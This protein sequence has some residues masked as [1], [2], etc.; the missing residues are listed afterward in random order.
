MALLPWTVLLLSALAKCDSFDYVIIGGGTSGLVIA[1]RLSEDPSVTVAVIE[2][3][4]DARDYPNVT[5][6]DNH[7]LSYINASIDWQYY[8]VPQEGLGGRSIL[9]HAGRALGGSSDINSMDYLRGD[10]AQYDAWER[11]GNEGWNWDT[12]SPYFKLSENFTI[13][14]P[15]QIAEGAT[16]DEQAHGEDGFL[17]TG[18]RPGLDNSSFYGDYLQTWSEL[19]IPRILD[20]NGGATEGFSLFPQTLDRDANVRES[21]ARAYYEPV[22]DR[23]NLTVIQGTVSRITWC[24]KS[25]DDVVASGVEYVDPSGELSHVDVSKEA[26]ISAGVYRSPLVLEASGI[27]NSNIL[28][29]YGI[30]TQVELPSVG[31]GMQEQQMVAVAFSVTQDIE[32]FTPYVTFLSAQDIFGNDTSSVAGT[33]EAEISA[34]AQTISES[35]GGALS[36]EVLEKRFGIQHDLFF[37]DNTT[38]VETLPVTGPGIVGSVF[39][40]LLPFSWGSV[41]LNTSSAADYPLIDPNYIALDIDLEILTGAGRVVRNLFNTA[42]L[43]SW[44]VDQAGFGV[45]TVS[46]TNDEWSDYI[47]EQVTTDWHT[48]GTCAML[49]QDLGGVVDSRLK[50]YG[51]QNVRIVDASVIPLQ[52][53]GHP[54][55]TLYALAERAAD[56]IKEDQVA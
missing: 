9:Y 27:G 20:A 41:H 2:A 7:D 17:T 4:P 26:I 31:E 24:E 56:L 25:G 5:R 35:S 42:P 52:M 46:A 23:P 6:I 44:V 11:L 30:E 53:S 3:G 36:P 22:D 32:G 51:T 28:S 18:Y 14:T 37:K 33:T 48:V 10:K 15:E 8:S 38:L 55:A 13:P 1:N 34:W 39:W 45:P 21:S 47:K 50:V 40:T 54:T 49:P 12:L 19:G 43:S 16:F 29:Q